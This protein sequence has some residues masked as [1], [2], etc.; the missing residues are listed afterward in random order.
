MVQWVECLLCK[1]EDLTLGPRNHI[2][3]DTA[4]G[5]C[6]TIASKA[7]WEADTGEPLEAQGSA[8]MT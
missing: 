1:R 3:P 5:A 2:K 7:R 8:G 6:N 4:A